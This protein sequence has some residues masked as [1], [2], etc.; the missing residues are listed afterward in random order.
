MCHVCSG[1]CDSQSRYLFLITLVRKDFQRRRGRFTLA[2]KGKLVANE[3]AAPS[4]N[5]PRRM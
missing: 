4:E 3:T 5:I 2:I 1:K